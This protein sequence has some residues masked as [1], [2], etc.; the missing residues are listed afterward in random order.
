M[1]KRHRRLIL[2][3]IL[4]VVIYIFVISFLANSRKYEINRSDFV[5]NWVS[6]YEQANYK[7]SH[8]HNPPKGA[9]G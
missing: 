1:K 2:I 9:C 4:I 8:T 5:G 6:N 3:V 7:Y